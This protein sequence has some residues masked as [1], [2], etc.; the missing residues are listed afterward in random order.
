MVGCV[1]MMTAQKKVF[2]K[3][4]DLRSPSVIFGQFKS[5]LMEKKISCKLFPLRRAKGCKK[6]GKKKKF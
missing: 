4:L 6:V 2:Y 1:R 5:D 3:K